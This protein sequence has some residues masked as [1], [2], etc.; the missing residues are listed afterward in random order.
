M[1]VNSNTFTPVDRIPVTP[2]VVKRVLPSLSAGAV[3]NVLVAGES[4]S[5][6]Y[7]LIANGERLY[8]LSQQKL[9]I[10][11]TYQLQVSGFDKSGQ[12]VMRVLTDAPPAIQGALQQRLTQQLEP[13]R[14]LQT[15]FTIIQTG[16]PL[17]QHPEFTNFLAALAQRRDISTGARLNE[18]IK[19][20]G[21]FFEHLLQMSGDKPSTDLKGALL[22]LREWLAA[23][24]KQPRSNGSGAVSIQ[25]EE[26]DDGNYRLLGAAPSSQPLLSKPPLPRPPTLLPLPNA[27]YANTQDATKRPFSF[28]SLAAA[29][30]LDLTTIQGLKRAVDGAISRIEAQ[31]L[32]SLQAQHQQQTFLL[33]E[34]PVV[35][36]GQVSTWHFNIREEPDEDSTADAQS[37]TWSVVLSVELPAVGPLS[38]HLTHSRQETT[39][40]FYSERRPV[41]GLIDS[42]IPGFVNRL[43]NLGL[44]G[45]SLSSHLGK[46]PASQEPD[47]DYPSVHATA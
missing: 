41:C 23:R 38:I 36:R 15:L 39:I 20:S 27:A 42:A 12:L 5:G 29:E 10:G 11:G 45:V 26:G 21:L 19:S 34:I 37:K 24:L 30:T 22:V 28:N 35:V 13:G 46:L 9:D 44:D 8:A 2:Q 47:I 16:S 31:Q 1:W 18:R 43:E 32:L 14:L 3:L 25:N 4:K 7:Q 40:N 33:F 6:A 17:A